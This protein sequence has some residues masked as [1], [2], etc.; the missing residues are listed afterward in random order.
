MRKTRIRTVGF[1]TGLP[2]LFV[3]LLS[4][5][6]FAQNVQSPNGR[7]SLSFALSVEGEPTY[8]LSIQW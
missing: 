4:L 2:I 1:S 5:N 7:L 8:A 3:L 6:T